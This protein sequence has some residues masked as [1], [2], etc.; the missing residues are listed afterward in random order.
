MEGVRPQSTAHAELIVSENFLPLIVNMEPQQIIEPVIEPVGNPIAV[1]GPSAGQVVRLVIPDI[2]VDR[3]VVPMD[4]KRG[5]GNQVEWNTDALFANNNRSDLVGQMATSVNPGDGGNIVLVG[6]N[7]NNGW[8]A[9]AGV[10]V[11]LQKLHPG[12]VILV[13]ASDGREFRYVVKIVKKV[14]WSKQNSAE[15]QKHQK[16]LWPTE[17]EQLT[18]VTC[19]GEVL[20]TWSARIYV[21]AVPET[22][23]G[24]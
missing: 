14:P 6:H 4:F 19:G 16:Y 5:D 11:N 23:T 2:N 10:F 17:N 1:L 18:L 3:A 15:L 9:S 13:T 21:V 12:S 8:N 20:F 7:Y 24:G 22:K